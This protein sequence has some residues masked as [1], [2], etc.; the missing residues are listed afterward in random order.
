MTYFGKVFTLER[1]ENFE[2][3]INSVGLPSE[4]AELSTKT[5]PSLKLEKDGDTYTLTAF[6]ENFKREIKFKSGVEFD[7]EIVPGTK[8]KST[9][10]AEGDKLTHVQETA[11]GTATYVREF[12]DKQVVVTLTNTK[13][14][15]VARRYYKAI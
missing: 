8:V 7:E 15:G 1:N 2:E 6:S 5:K 10:T 9:I 3:F 4:K 14:N 13:W 11:D 12:S